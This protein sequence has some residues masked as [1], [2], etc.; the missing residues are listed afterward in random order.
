[1]MTE[2]EEFLQSVLWHHSTVKQASRQSEN[3]TWLPTGGKPKKV[4][5][6]PKE[7]RERKKVR[8]KVREGGNCERETRLSHLLREGKKIRYLFLHFHSVIYFKSYST[9]WLLH[10]THFNMF[11]SLQWLHTIQIPVIL[12]FARYTGDITTATWE[13]LCF[14]LKSQFL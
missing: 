10:S 13:Y 4:T 14:C 8:V 3:Q 9:I 7:E 1:M 6:Q 5:V 11:Y 2:K 12:H